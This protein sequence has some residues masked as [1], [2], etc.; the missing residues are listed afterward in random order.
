VNL[1]GLLS[2]LFNRF[3]EAAPSIAWWSQKQQK[4]EKT[5]KIC[6]MRS[7]KYETTTLRREETTQVAVDDGFCCF[8]LSFCRAFDLQDILRIIQETLIV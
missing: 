1:F 4:R 2:E 5:K 8:L 3:R 6:L 7:H